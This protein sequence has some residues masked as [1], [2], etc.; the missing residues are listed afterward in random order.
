MVRE[1]D[2]LVVLKKIVSQHG[3]QAAAAA[4]LGV[5]PQFLGDLL[6]GRRDCSQKVLE[7][8]GLRRTVVA[9]ARLPGGG[10]F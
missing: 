1:I 10:G 2:P 6:H 9:A 7:R 3:S 8:M 5:S 4:A